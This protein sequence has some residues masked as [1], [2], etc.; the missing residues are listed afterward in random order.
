MLHQTIAPSYVHQDCELT[1]R[2]AL[3]EFY[4]RNTDALRETG[5]A[6]K[7]D[8]FRRHDTIHVVFG[9]DTSLHDEALADMWTIF[10]SDLGFR[11]YLK[12]LG[13]L[14]D[15]LANIFKDT[16]KTHLVRE[17]MAAVSDMLRVIGRGRRMRDKWPW[18]AHQQYLDIPLRDV[19]RRLNIEVI[20]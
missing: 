2:Q 6:L 17:V 19:R 10:A 5:D 3:E 15:D 11:N 4:G 9:C 12:Y 1:I 18:E 16:S 7:D 14:Q 20:N 13:P 8:F